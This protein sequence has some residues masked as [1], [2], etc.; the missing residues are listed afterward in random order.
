MKDWYKDK[1]LREETFDAEYQDELMPRLQP[2]SSDIFSSSKTNWQPGFKNI[3]ADLD[4][5]DDSFPYRY[6]YSLLKH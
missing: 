1:E 5:L 4:D 3:Y 2:V 6:D